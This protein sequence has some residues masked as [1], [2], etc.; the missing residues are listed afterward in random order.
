MAPSRPTASR[1]AAPADGKAAVDAFMAQSTH[2][3]KDAIE[4]LRGIVLAV[5]ASVTEGIRWNAPSFRSS[6]WF[7][8]THLRCRRGIGLIL[9][10]GAKVRALPPGGL[11]IDDP[12]G[13]L[14]WL[15][16]DRAMLEFDGLGELQQ[17]TP[18]VLALLRQWIRQV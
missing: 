4:A 9:H 3:H 6:E 10:L 5:D 15:G 1:G 14:K 8:T 11:V 18:A 13:L 7:A 16:P 17:R 12:S 2:A